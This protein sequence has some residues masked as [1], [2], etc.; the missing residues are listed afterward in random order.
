MDNLVTQLEIIWPEAPGKGQV[1][2]VAPGLFWARLPL[3][4][5]LNHVNVW[6]LAEEG[7]W[8]VVDTG[9]G[10]QELLDIWQALE[11]GPMRDLPISRVVATHGH[12]DHIGLA[13]WLVERHKAEFVGTF[14]EWNW[15]RISHIHDV[16]GA[17]ETH[18]AYLVRNGFDPE[19][20]AGMVKSRR[21]FIDLATPVP[22][23]IVEI[24]DGE[25]FRMGGRDWDVIVT[26][27]H[28]FEHASFFDRASGILIA[29]D[30]LLPKISP[31]IAVYETMPKGDPLGDYLAS[32]GRF[33]H[34]PADV[35]VLP[36]H[37]MPYRGIHERIG[38]LREHHRN[39]LEATLEILATPRSGVDLA[40][41]MFPHVEGPDNIGFAL[42]ETLA[43]VNYLLRRGMAD[44]IEGPDGQVSFVARQNRDR[45]EI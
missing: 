11:A 10:T 25:V 43:H 1:R 12:V 41:S 30:H 44:E 3:P 37:G 9:C 5:R 28:A 15:A 29:G 33:S 8:T 36:S 23:S 32:F 35:L 6:L 16:P 40:K 45:L 21:R 31:V 24:R 19:V 39:R 22:G 13:G 14:G 17:A 42:G 2:E 34:I 26:P 27:G 38:Q 7:G 4:F 18:Q 20:A